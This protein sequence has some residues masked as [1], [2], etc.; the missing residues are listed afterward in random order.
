MTTEDRGSQLVAAVAALLQRYTDRSELTVGYATT[1]AGAPRPIR[2]DL[3]GNPRFDELVEQVRTAC[4]TGEPPTDHA[5]AL[6]AVIALDQDPPIGE[7]HGLW[8]SEHQ[9]PDGA[10]LRVRNEAG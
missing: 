5:S 9:T 7:A 10:E 2:L 3:S 1:A 4:D 6:D 8:V